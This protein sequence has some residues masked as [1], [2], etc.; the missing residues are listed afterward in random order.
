MGVLMAVGSIGSVAIP[1]LMQLFSYQKGPV[2]V[3]YRLSVLVLVVLSSLACG[4]TLFI[5]R[6]TGPD[7]KRHK[8]GKGK[9]NE[10]K[11]AS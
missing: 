1:L 6:E 11:G 2:L 9:T 4:L 7:A 3:D 5:V 8:E 10:V